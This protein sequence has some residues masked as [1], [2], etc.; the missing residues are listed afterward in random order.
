M[1]MEYNN[2]FHFHDRLILL[3]H[4]AFIYQHQDLLRFRAVLSNV[5]FTNFIDLRLCFS[6]TLTV[7][8][9]VVIQ[10]SWQRCSV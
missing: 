1:I 8:L 6:G 7:N 4:V 2:Y 9:C 5:G 10:E 3:L